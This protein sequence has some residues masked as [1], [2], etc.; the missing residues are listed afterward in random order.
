MERH[1]GCFFRLNAGFSLLDSEF[2]T[3]CRFVVSSDL[4]G[5]HKVFFASRCRIVYN[6]V[7]CCVRRPIFCNG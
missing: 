4:A 3:A 1:D 7:A 6:L 5:N 2:R